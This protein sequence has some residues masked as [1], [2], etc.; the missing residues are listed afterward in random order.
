MINESYVEVL[1]KKKPSTAMKFLKML[2]ITMTV[3]M[4][5]FGMGGI[6]IAII[7]AIVLGV[8]AYILG[9]FEEVE[10][11]YTY[12]DRELQIDRILAKSKRKRMETL[13][14]NK[15]EILAPMNSYRLDSYKN[16]EY[17]VVDYSRKVDEKPETR[18]LLYMAGEKKVILEP[19]MEMVKVIQN[20]A[21]RKVF[22]D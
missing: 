6:L 13:D 4:V 10:Y 5:L 14:L 18:Y 16:R 7:P 15:M 1:V 22:K 8:A 11:E 19:N 12:I 17:K 21:P 2:C 3:A 20:I 9:L